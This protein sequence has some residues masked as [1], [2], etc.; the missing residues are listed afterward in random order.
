MRKEFL[1]TFRSVTFAQRAERALRRRDI[2]CQLQRTPKILTSRGC[3][4]CL[5]FRE[6]EA[7]RAV[8]VLQ[9]EQISYEKLYEISA[10]GTPEEKLL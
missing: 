4:Y 3:G 6:V 10:D 9:S 1:V 7:L 2:F 8:A 5:R